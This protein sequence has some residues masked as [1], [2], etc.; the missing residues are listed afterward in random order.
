MEHRERF[1]LPDKKKVCKQ[2]LSTPWKWTR[3]L[4][5]LQSSG[6]KKRGASWNSGSLQPLRQCQ[7]HHQTFCC[8]K[9][10]PSLFMPLLTG[11]YLKLKVF[12]V[13]IPTLPSLSP[14]LSLTLCIQ[15]FFN[16]SIMANS[17]GSEARLPRSIAQL[18]CL[19]V[20]NFGQV[21]SPLCASGS[22]SI[23]WG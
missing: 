5:L 10:A 6:R 23:K 20:G 15:S 22:S 17:T 13:D 1:S 14:A 8:R 3:D 2:K 4:G 12:I 11:H 21:I 19:L 7:K 18:Y 9:I 16:Y